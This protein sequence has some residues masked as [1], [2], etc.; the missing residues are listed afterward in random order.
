[1]VRFRLKVSGL[2]SHNVMNG[3]EMQCPFCTDKTED[4]RHFLLECD[5]Y[6][7]IREKYLQRYMQY[8]PYRSYMFLIDGQ[9]HIKTKHTAMFI[10][11]ALKRR[12]QLLQEE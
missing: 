10:H 8:I 5:T 7:D 3:Q 11:Y 1:M 2:H 9:G 4:E 12:R 6:K